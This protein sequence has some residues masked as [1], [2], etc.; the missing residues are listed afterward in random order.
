M[1]SGS[2]SKRARSV[3]SVTNKKN[4]GGNKKA[5]LAPRSTGPVEFR[6]TALNKQGVN[7]KIH[8]AGLPC[9]ETYRNN[10]GGQCA[11]GVG[12][13]ASTRAR[14][15]RNLG[16]DSKQ[17]EV[18]SSTYYY[19]GPNATPIA[20]KGLFQIQI[21][22]IERAFINLAFGFSINDNKEIV[23]ASILNT[24]DSAPVFWSSPSA[25][26]IR[27]KGSLGENISG[28]AL[29]IN[30][31]KQIVGYIDVNGNQKP[32]FWNSP[33]SNAV[34]LEDAS[35]DGV[36]NAININGN[37]VGELNNQPVYWDNTNR[38]TNVTVLKDS[39]GNPATGNARDINDDDNII[40]FVI[41]GNNGFPFYWDNETSN[42]EQLKDKNGAT[43]TIDGEATSINNNKNI[44]GFQDT[45]AVFWTNK[46][47][48]KSEVLQS[49]SSDYRALS[50][51]N[52]KEIV[53][54]GVI[55]SNNS[56]STLY[57]SNENATAIRIRT[58]L[59]AI[60]NEFFILAG[61]S[62]NNNNGNFIISVPIDFFN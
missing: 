28:V 8:Q 3:Q 46:D 51:N 30:N 49:N 11:G 43:N 47:S 61:V 4:C 21:P 33:T 27:L 55:D 60:L 48:I 45:D 57:W 35:R 20:L 17:I 59:E 14:G 62:I 38:E 9:P 32:A 34:L 31:N 26:P 41:D 29:D 5:G 7:F 54:G 23:G 25:T 58:P 6:N 36:A 24:G 42:G 40:G 44:V 1:P 50:L 16:G 53:G 12:A 19:D 13:L 39:T 22:I 15:C 52:D 18:Y 37:I 10:P 2:F 56:I